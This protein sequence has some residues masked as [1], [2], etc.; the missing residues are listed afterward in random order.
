MLFMTL[1]P[2]T[3]VLQYFKYIEQRN[4]VGLHC[5]GE[6]FALALCCLLVI[7]LILIQSP[8]TAPKLQR[9]HRANGLTCHSCLVNHELKTLLNTSLFYF[10]SVAPRIFFQNEKSFT[11]KDIY[12]YEEDFCTFLAISIGASLHESLISTQFD[13]IL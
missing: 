10:C 3:W 5:M 9:S 6:N 4:R 8:P 7:E 2:S 12:L 13:P 11:L 1:S